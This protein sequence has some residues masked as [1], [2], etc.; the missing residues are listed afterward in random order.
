MTLKLSVIGG[1]LGAG[2]TTLLNRLLRHATQRYGVIVNDFGSINVDAGLIVGQ[3]QGVIALANGCVCCAAGDDMGDALH[4]IAG[5]TPPPDHVLIEASG[6]SDPWRIAQLALIEPGFDLQPLLVLADASA[7]ETQLADRW[8]ADAVSS[9]FTYAE[10]IV[11]TK[12]DLV[13]AAT[14]DRLRRRLAELG[15]RARIVA[16]PVEEAA[17]CFTPPP[18][19]RPTTAL[20][21]P[22][23]A[24]RLVWIASYR[25]P[26]G[27][28]PAVSSVRPT[29]FSHAAASPLSTRARSTL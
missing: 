16:G 28:V 20:C 23:C 4:R 24:Y 15:P 22:R 17:L 29:D 27:A 1:F 11:L 9:Q 21:E 14:Q 12:T 5:R 2:K 10:L 8:I 19:A 26:F 18:R 13:D 7:L 25:L 3:D 6:V